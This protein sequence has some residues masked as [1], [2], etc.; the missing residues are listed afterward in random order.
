[1]GIEIEAKIRVESLEPVR[2][3]LAG[4]GVKCAGTVYQ[5]D[6]YFDS[7][8]N[9][10]KRGDR[11]LR[12]RIE[13]TEA[14]QKIKLTY[15]GPR[16]GGAF[17]NRV[18][19]EFGVDDERAAGELLNELGYRQGV[20]VEKTREVYRFG[21]CEIGL[22][23]LSGV[24]LFVEIEGASEEAI[25]AVQKTLGLAEFAHTSES[26]ASMVE[27]FKSEKH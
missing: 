22:D 19:I 16:Q 1:M 14:K 25:H 15:K 4:L 20:I 17:K 6:I 10:M 5:R 12:L 9:E 24:G 18:E 26:Y 27:K 3:R 23:S 13:K 21:D 7:A 8:G 2:E 11:A